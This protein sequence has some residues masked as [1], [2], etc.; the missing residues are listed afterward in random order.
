MR[1]SSIL[2]LPPRN[3]CVLRLSAL[4]DVTHVIPLIRQIQRQWP[5]CRI[6]WICGAFEYNFLKLIEGV[7]FIRFDKKE[8]FKAYLSLRKQLCED[9]FDVLLHMQVSARANLA[10]MFVNA[11]VR[12]G[13]DTDR[14]RDLHRLFIN[15]SVP[16]ASMQHQQDGFLSFGTPLGLRQ[17]SPDWDLPILS[18]IHI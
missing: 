8:G 13:W 12:L 14:S 4:G 11:D 15:R 17:S 2:K 10:S 1:N 6:T 16:V 7:R 18:L 9:Y 5:D 3:L